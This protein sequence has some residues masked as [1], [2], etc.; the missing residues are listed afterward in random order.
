MNSTYL[1]DK[2]IS[3]ISHAISRQMALMCAGAM[4]AFFGSMSLARAQ[5]VPVTAGFRD[6]YFGTRSNSTPTGEKPQSKL[7]WNDGI[8][9]GSLWDPPPRRSTSHRFDVAPQTR[10]S[11]GT[12]IDERANAKAD[13]L[14]DGQRLYVVSNIFTHSPGPTTVE[15]AGRLYRYSYN[16][17]AKTYSLDAGFPVNVNGSISETLVLAKDATGKLWVTWTEGGK[18]KVNRSLD[19]DRSWGT[20]FDLPAQ[21]ND[22]VDDDISTVIAFG[23]AALPGGTKIGIMWSNQNAQTTYF[24]A[25]LDGNADEDWERR[26]EALADPVLGD[27]SYDHINLK[28]ACDQDGNIYAATKTS[29]TRSD[30]PL[31]Y[32][33]KRDAAGNWTRH[34]FSKASDGHTRPIV[35]IDGE[36]NKAYVFAMSNQT[37][38]AAIYMKSTDLDN[39][40][41]P[42]GLGTPVI[43]SDTDL[44]ISNP[45]S[46]KQCVNGTTNILVLSSDQDT[47]YY[48]HNY[49]D[50]EGGPPNGVTEDKE[51]LLPTAL[52]LSQNYPNPFHTGSRIEYTLPQQTHV[53][54]AIYDALGRQV[55]QLVDELQ[56]A[57]S[58]QIF[59]NGQNDRGARVPAGAY[60]MRLEVVGLQCTRKITLLK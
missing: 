6:F 4:L 44:N 17:A 54:L 55:R 23:S 9:W 20:P 5:S 43:Q 52:Q 7:W 24:A 21:G 2:K 36:N 18:V 39:I 59:W 41:F 40:S 13:A 22:I 58:Q 26:E 11:T 57:G 49:L 8:W 42:P 1:T 37:G 14:W 35:L 31:I 53:R 46:T 28:P 30:Y 16:E 3:A 48:L 38:T 27:I 12:A 60:W 50:L 56:P 15:N 32:L 19:D 51:C 45:T 34:L 33:L 25:H 47:R 29:L 10:T